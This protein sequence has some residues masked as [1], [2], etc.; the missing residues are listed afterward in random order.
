[1]IQQTPEWYQA[2]IGR[3][4]ASRCADLMAK[5]KSGYSTSRNNYM[6]EL[7]IARITGEYPESYTSP[8]M[9]WGIDTETQAR[10]AYEIATYTPVSQAGFILHPDNSEV[11]CSPDG[12][13][14]E[15][16]GL[17][18]KCPNSATHLDT[19][20]TGKIDRKYLLQI[21]FSMWVT[22][23]KWWDYVSYDPRFPEHMRLF[24]SRVDRDETIILEI[25][26]EVEKFLDEM[27]AK[28]KK[29]EAFN[30]L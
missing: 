9:Q 22:N 4:S 11:G 23:R 10:E 16:G 12:L 8:S 20:L 25:K 18:I 1:M 5:T 14:G 21:Q 2:K 3:V 24:I 30:G 27:K 19:L 28:L 17:E 13:I 29:L 6:T 26:A 7:I 15:D